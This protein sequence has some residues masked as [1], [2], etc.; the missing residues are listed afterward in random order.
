M[1]PNTKFIFFWQ[2]LMPSPKQFHVKNQCFSNCAL[3]YTWCQEGLRAECPLA[4]LVYTLCS[5]VFIVQE[6][7]RESLIICRSFSSKQT[8]KTVKTQNKAGSC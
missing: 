1:N 2:T 3:A 7:I 4:E 5:L 8:F 6:V